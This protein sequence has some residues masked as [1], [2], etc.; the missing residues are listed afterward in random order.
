MVSYNA[1]GQGYDKPTGNLRGE[2][3][4]SPHSLRSYPPGAS[5]EPI[6]SSQARRVTTARE[7]GPPV[8]HRSGMVLT[9]RGCRMLGPERA[10]LLSRQARTGEHFFPSP[11]R[12]LGQSSYERFTLSLIYLVAQG[13]HFTHS[14]LAGESTTPF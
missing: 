13:A 9:L 6:T 1:I 7:A 4:K 14:K 5:N 2:R 10:P 8:P 12:L 3:D 11:P